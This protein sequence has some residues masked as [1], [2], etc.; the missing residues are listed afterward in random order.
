MNKYILLGKCDDTVGIVSL[1]SEWIHSIGGNI[2]DLEQFVNQEQKR[3]FIR[4]EWSLKEK[5]P[6]SELCQQF[7]STIGDKLEIQFNIN[8][9][10]KKSK[11]A[12][13]VSQ[14]DHCLWDLLARY[15]QPN[16]EVEIPVII[17][18]HRTCEKIASMFGI[19]FIF[20]DSKT[21][22]KEK[23]EKQQM[24]ILKENQI[25]FVVLARY[26]Q[27]LSDSFVKKWENKIINIHHSFLPA[28]PGAKPYHQAHKRGVK[29]IGASA[30]YVTSELD[31]GPIIE[32]EVTR[33]TH[34]D[35]VTSLL[36]KGRELEK[37]VLSRAV[38]LHLSYYIIVEKNRTYILK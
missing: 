32:Q 5:V 22:T 35:D 30:H 20:I 12:I 11:M 4:L 16:T 8:D 37:V 21:Q 6:V 9:K 24:E 2:L 29:V 18:N 23:M 14:L 31:A 33:V 25:D 27:I 38:Q 15:H 10:S 7:K 13:F 3:F 26:M 36:S 19:K 1:I 17:S 34:R 28:F